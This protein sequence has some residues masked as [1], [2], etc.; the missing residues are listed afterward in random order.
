MTYSFTEQITYIIGAT[1][2]HFVTPNAIKGAAGTSVGAI[3]IDDANAGLKLQS[4]VTID[5]IEANADL[6]NREVNDF[7]DET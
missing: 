7:V 3:V 4:R 2:T 5:K 1:A 6:T